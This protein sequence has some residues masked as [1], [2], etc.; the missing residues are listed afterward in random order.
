MVFG[1]CLPR[2]SF[3]KGAVYE[4]MSV[5]GAKRPRV[6]FGWCVPGLR[7]ISSAGCGL[8]RE[9]RNVLPSRPGVSILGWGHACAGG[10]NTGA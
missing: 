10:R 6:R 3:E 7:L 9:L 4:C 2:H 8:Y 1:F 5:F